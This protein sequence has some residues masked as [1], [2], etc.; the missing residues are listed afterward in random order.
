[1][2]GFQF[3]D[4]VD[5]TTVVNPITGSTYQWKFPP[6][7][8]VV[9]TKHQGTISDILWE[10]DSP[11]DPVDNYKLWY[12]TDTLE[13]Y[14]HYCDSNGTCAWV[15][16]SAPITMIQDLD[17]GV[18][19]LRQDLNQTNIAVAENENR[20]GRTIEFSPIAPTIYEDIEVTTDLYDVDGTTVIGQNIE[21]F[22]NE[23]N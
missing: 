2:A 23:L 8:W 5:A 12:S 20:I 1:M 18:F 14:F 15:P 16:T 4:P 9:T 6:G 13:L 19:E 7:K 11:P 3:P 10:G 17:E 21:Y 22:F